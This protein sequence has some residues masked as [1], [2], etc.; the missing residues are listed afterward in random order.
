MAEKLSSSRVTS[1]AHT[2]HMA[3]LS[4]GAHVYVNNGVP[5]FYLWS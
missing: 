3:L 4:P 2:E 5:V 1:R